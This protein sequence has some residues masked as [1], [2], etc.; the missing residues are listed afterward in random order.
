MGYSWLRC[1]P[2]KSRCELMY[3]SII[4]LLSMLILPFP[5]LNA[6]TMAEIFAEQASVESVTEEPSKNTLSRTPWQMHDGLEVT[7]ENPLGLVEF[8]CKG[9]KHGANCFYDDATIP[10]A[11]DSR[12]REAPD[13]DIIN[14]ELPRSRVCEAPVTCMAFGDFTYFQTFVNIPQN[15]VL[16][17][18][19]I[20]FIGMDDGSRITIYNS[21]FPEGIVLAGSYVYLKG[22]G[23]SNLAEYVVIG[24]NNRVVVTQVDDCCSQ[25]RLKEAKVI[26]NGETTEVAC[27]MSNISLVLVTD[28]SASETSWFISNTSNDVMYSGNNL[29]NN[30]TYTELFELSSGYYEFTI[31]DSQGNGLNGS[32]QLIDGAGGLIKQSKAFDQSDSTSFCVK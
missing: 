22:S 3:K 21:K 31:N 16:N 15:T 19:R 25:N 29:V 14:F 9:N 10:T 32:Y 7:N 26:I 23:T 11:I 2:F 18:F 13:G 8:T 30:H 4:C 12:W 17:D 6:E 1:R 27:H 28:D 24:E 5:Y 20:S